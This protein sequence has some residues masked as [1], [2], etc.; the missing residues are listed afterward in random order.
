M[1][2]IGDLFFYV[3]GGFFLGIF[4][5]VKGFMW[6]RQKQLM[7]NMPTS[8]IR[9]LA[10]GLAEVFGEV[11]PAEGK[12]LKSPLSARDCVYYRYT[13]EEYRQSGKSSHWAT[14]RKGEDGTHFFLKDETGLVLVDPKGAK[15]DIPRDFLFESHMGK[16][17]PDTVRQFL[18]A[19][20]L[21]FEGWLFGIN[22]KMRYSEYFIAPKDKLYI[23]GTASDNPFVEDAT[24]KQGIE[25]IMITK[26]EHEKFYY[27][28]DKSEREILG[29]LRLKAMGGIFGGALL[30]VGCLALILLYIGV[31]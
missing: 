29:S 27:I 15:V 10:M 22:K 8:K 25:D 9:S 17:P 18:K 20:N 6:F 23:M 14:I 12:I 16:D 2:D 1:S 28:S 31:L 30:A 3:I 26:G 13:I 4:L 24:A 11:V 7:E 21:S 5:F 19:N